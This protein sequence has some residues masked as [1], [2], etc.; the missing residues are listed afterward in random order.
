MKIRCIAIDDEPPALRIIKEYCSR[1]PYLDLLSCITNPFEAVQ[2][3]RLQKPDLLFLDIQMPDINGL[4]IADKL[5]KQ[6]IFI[7]STA[8]SKYALDGFNLNAVDFLLKPY[9]FDRFLK[10]VEKAKT[11]IEY[12]SSQ[13]SSTT[14]AFILIKHD[15]Q[16][17]KIFLSDI[18]FVEALDNYI[19]IHTTTKNYITLMSMKL[20]ISTLPAQEFIRV[21]K[22]FIVRLDKIKSFNKESIAISNTKIPIGRVYLQDFLKQTSQ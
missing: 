16:N 18:L 12:N 13:T 22:S 15:Y 8:H 2:Q 11:Q 1:I 10:A 9:D 4:S 20:I 7:F 21:H 3:I 14:G 5:E 19:K 6:P 17:V